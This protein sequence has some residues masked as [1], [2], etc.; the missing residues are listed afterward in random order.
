MSGWGKSRGSRTR[1]IRRLFDAGIRLNVG[2]DDPLVFGTSLSRGVP[3]S[4][5]AA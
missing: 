1:L 3:R 2:S 4:T 5:T